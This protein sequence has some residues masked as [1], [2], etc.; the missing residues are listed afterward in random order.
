MYN[1]KYTTKTP[2]MYYI[3]PFYYPFTV[4]CFKIN[5]IMIQLHFLQLSPHYFMIFIMKDN[6]PY[7]L[8]VSYMCH[9]CSHYVHIVYIHYTKKDI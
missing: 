4:Q 3:Q 7:L 5:L 8:H 9:F 2:P 6:K 1:L